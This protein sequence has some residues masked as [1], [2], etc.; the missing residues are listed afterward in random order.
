MCFKGPKTNKEFRTIAASYF[1]RVPNHKSTIVRW[2]R[3]VKLDKEKAEGFSAL[4]G[5][6]ICAH[7]GDFKARRR[8]SQ[9]AKPNA[10]SL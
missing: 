5:N 4:K 2:R 9:F 3:N 6:P 7:L 10:A 8:L 1:E